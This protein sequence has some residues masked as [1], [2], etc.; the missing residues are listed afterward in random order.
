MNVTVDI[1]NACDDDEQPPPSSSIS[2]WVKA[3]ITAHN[4]LTPTDNAIANAEVSIRFVNTDEMQGLNHQY[5]D[6]PKPTN[7]LSFPADLPEEIAH[8]LLG[9]II[10]CNNVVAQ[11]AI[12]QQKTTQAHWCHMVV[13]GTLHLLGYD[14]IDDEDARQMEGIETKILES[15]NFPNPYIDTVACK[16]IQ[17]YS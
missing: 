5:R 11:E 12:E 15:L 16:P 6:K 4:Q 8:P 13:H 14:H 9:D 2:D 7:V 3:A 17:H 10:I 1:D